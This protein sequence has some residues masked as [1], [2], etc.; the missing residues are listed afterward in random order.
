MV[1]SRQRFGF[2]IHSRED[3]VN[4]KGSRKKRIRVVLLVLA[5]IASMLTL[6]FVAIDRGRPSAI[7]LASASNE[8]TVSFGQY[9]DAI[10][11]AE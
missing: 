6:A 3:K 8:S 9:Q 7:E 11:R 5:A 10:A 1:S 4:T 2:R